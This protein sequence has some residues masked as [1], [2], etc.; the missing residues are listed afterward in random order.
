[1]EHDGATDAVDL[2]LAAVDLP[3]DWESAV[4]SCSQPAKRSANDAGDGEH[5]VDSKWVALQPCMQ[6]DAQLQPSDDEAVKSE[7]GAARKPNDVGATDVDVDM[8]E[9]P[10][11]RWLQQDKAAVRGTPH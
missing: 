2:T 9:E 10:N 4:G 5:E 11:E 3:L 8:G 7:G 1:M 6:L